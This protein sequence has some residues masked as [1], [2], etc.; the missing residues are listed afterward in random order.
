M[1][2]TAKNF[3]TGDLNSLEAAPETPWIS[4]ISKLVF[5]DTL[6]TEPLGKSS[7]SAKSPSPV[8]KVLPTGMVPPIPI[9]SGDLAPNGVTISKLPL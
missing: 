6:I 8:T 3:P 4:V 9:A 1:A 2:I 7:T 5:S